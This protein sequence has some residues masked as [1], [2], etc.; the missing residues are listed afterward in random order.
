VRPKGILPR[1]RIPD[2]RLDGVK[3]PKGCKMVSINVKE[4]L[5]VLMW[6]WEWGWGICQQDE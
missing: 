6:G 5:N 4:M 1:V 3:S 2:Q